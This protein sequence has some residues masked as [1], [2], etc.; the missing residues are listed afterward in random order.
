MKMFKDLFTKYYQD[1]K[2]RQQKKL[3]K[4]IKVFLK[5]QNS[6]NMLIK[7]TKTFQ[8]TKS[9]SFFSIKK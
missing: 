8:K 7:E 5:K 2:E 1:N 3:V 9:K 4:D 6:N